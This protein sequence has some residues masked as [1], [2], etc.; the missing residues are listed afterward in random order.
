MLWLMV[1]LAC[2]DGYPD[3]PFFESC[4]DNADCGEFECLA[5]PWSD[6]GS[7]AMVCSLPCDKDEDCP[8]IRTGHCGQIPLLCTNGVCKDSTGC[9]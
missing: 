9:K 2:N 6:T 8:L 1:L 4:T 3:E 5:D 7:D